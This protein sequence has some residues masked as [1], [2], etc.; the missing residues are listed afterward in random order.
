MSNS[1][2]YS[3]EEWD[4]LHPLPIKCD[5]R[6]LK[7][8]YMTQCMRSVMKE[9]PDMP[10]NE[11]LNKAK[12]VALFGVLETAI[13]FVEKHQPQL[14]SDRQIAGFLQ[15]SSTTRELHKLFIKDYPHEGNY[16]DIYKQLEAELIKDWVMEAWGKWKKLKDPNC[17]ID[18]TVAMDDLQRDV[19]KVR[20]FLQDEIE[21][22]D[23]CP[24]E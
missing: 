13:L 17:F 19:K 8:K 9:N 5:M 3:S 20:Q 11:L 21:K 6:E 10:D 16:S 22:N 12:D 1:R 4:D 18:A 7:V 2:G 24:K 14:S 23:R 15:K